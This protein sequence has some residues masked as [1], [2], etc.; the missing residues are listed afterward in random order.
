MSQPWLK[1]IEKLK[2]K[3]TTSISNS[4]SLVELILINAISWEL[5]VGID[6]ARQGFDRPEPG[7]RKKLQA[8]VWPMA[9][10]KPFFLAWAGLFKSLD[11]PENLLAG[12]LYIKAIK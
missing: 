8:W 3:H 9:Y 4:T 5:R 1:V 7:L 6:Q 12:L 11:W 10:H 2:R